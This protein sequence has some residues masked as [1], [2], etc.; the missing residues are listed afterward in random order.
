MHYDVGKNAK[1]EQLG[2]AG[3]LWRTS[4]LQGIPIALTIY[5]IYNFCSLILIS[6]IHKHIIAVL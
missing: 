3:E 2:S 1:T 4:G 6:L 5:L